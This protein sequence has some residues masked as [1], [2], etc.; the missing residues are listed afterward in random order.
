MNTCTPIDHPARRPTGPL[1]APAAL[2]SRAARHRGPT[3]L[4][5]LGLLGL[6][7]LSISEE[8]GGLG[9]SMS[10]EVQAA[11]VLGQTSPVFRSLVGTNNGI[12][13]QVLVGFGSED[14]KARWLEPMASGEAVAS[15]ALTEPGEAVLK[16]VERM[17]QERPVLL[18]RR[19][20][21]VQHPQRRFHFHYLPPV[22][23]L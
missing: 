5:L 16:I 12:A 4:T 18:D 6:F 11:F 20:G 22:T 3:L 13:G 23:K 1:P 15:F 2:G 19:R 10:E 8:Y 14:Q 17:L 7:G 21:L 9:L